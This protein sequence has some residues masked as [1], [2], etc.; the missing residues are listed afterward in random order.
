MKPLIGITAQNREVNTS[1]GNEPAN[2]VVLT[3]SN[4]VLEAGGIPV[5]LP[6]LNAEAVPGLL[7]RL[8]GVVLTGGGDV[9]PSRYGLS[10][11]PTVYGVDR[12][13]DSFELALARQI[14][15]L[16][17]PVLAICRGLQVMNVAL[18]GTLVVDIQTQIDGGFDHFQSGEDAKRAHQALRFDE[19]CRM[20]GLFGTSELKVNS[21]HHQ[22]VAE[23]AP[24]L[25]PVAWSEDGVVEAVEPEDGQWP[26]LGVQ[27][28]PEHLVES[29]S[30]ARSLFET[31]VEAAAKA[32]T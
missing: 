12:A 18:G 23:P 15:D 11:H 32:S 1:Y 8:D 28:H 19:S 13:R 24:G 7:Q 17:K 2:P 21:L 6:I 20:A 25:R 4:A 22:A 29:E 27:W 16:K 10:E 14:A 9:D 30:A 26:M 31:L 3:Y 5:L